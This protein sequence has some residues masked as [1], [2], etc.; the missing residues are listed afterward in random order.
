LMFLL[1]NEKKPEKVKEKLAK[2][3]VGEMDF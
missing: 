1:G 3:L 2:P